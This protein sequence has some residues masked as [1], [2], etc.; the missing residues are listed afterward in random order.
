MAGAGD[1]AAGDGLGGD[2]GARGCARASADVDVVA[3]EATVVHPM[4][5]ARGWIDASG[6]AGL[7]VL[8]MGSSFYL[9]EGNDI[10]PICFN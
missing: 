5:E 2:G 10:Y 1:A 7:R 6:S 3:A 9:R 4:G 8:Q